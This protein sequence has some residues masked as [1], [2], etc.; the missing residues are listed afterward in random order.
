MFLNCVVTLA[1]FDHELQ[2]YLLGMDEGCEM[3]FALSPALPSVSPQWA[4]TQLKPMT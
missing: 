3:V 2:T 1:V 4:W